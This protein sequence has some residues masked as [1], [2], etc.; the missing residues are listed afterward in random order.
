MKNNFSSW[1][2]FFLP[3]HSSRGSIPSAQTPGGNREAFGDD[4]ITG[5]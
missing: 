4:H 3:G 1:C 5:V 2:I